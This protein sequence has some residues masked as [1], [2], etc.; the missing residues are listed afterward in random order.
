MVCVCSWLYDINLSVCLCVIEM[1][2]VRVCESVYLCVS[3]Y[4]VVSL[5]GACE[6]FVV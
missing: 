3:E 1:H 4:V 6:V 2:N 5:C